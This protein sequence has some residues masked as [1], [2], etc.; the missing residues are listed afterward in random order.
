MGRYTKLLDEEQKGQDVTENRQ[1]D[2]TPDRTVGVNKISDPRPDLVEDH[3]LWDKLLQISVNKGPQLAGP[4]VAMRQGGTR[5]K[6][7]EGGSYALRPEV[8]EGCWASEAAYKAE[9]QRLLGPHKAVLIELL[10]KLNDGLA[11][12]ARGLATDRQVML[13]KQALTEKRV[14]AIRCEALGGEVV[15]FAK[16][17]GDGRTNAPRGAVVYTLTELAN[18]QECPPTP[19]ELKQIHQVKKLFQGTV[20]T[21]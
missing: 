3:H 21:E 2:R 1:P 8:E 16:T 4:L 15:Y 13:I 19:Q 12:D 6:V 17:W 5:L 14:C 10:V 11:M 18:L 20:M 7:T 9:A